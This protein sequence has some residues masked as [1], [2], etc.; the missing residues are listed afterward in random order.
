MVRQIFESLQLSKWI[1]R[2]RSSFGGPHTPDF[3]KASGTEEAHHLA[4]RVAKA[5]A[6]T[7]VDVLTQPEFLQEVKREFADADDGAP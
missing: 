4:L 3:E 5:L 7:A 2:I 1:I 6:A